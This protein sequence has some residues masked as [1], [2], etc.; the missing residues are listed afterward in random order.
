[1]MVAASLNNIIGKNNKL[2]F[3]CKEDLRW[4]KFMTMD[5][6]C[7]VGRVTYE[8]LPKLP[9]RKLVVLS[10][11]AING[12]T[13]VTV[14]QLEKEIA[15]YKCDFLPKW[16]IGGKKVYE[17]CLSKNII[18]EIYLSRIQEECEGDVCLP[19][20]KGFRKVSELKL[21]KDCILERWNK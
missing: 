18:D 13:S 19:E 14:D 11:K 4:F 7:L 16:V 21:S 2:P 1:M 17:F 10:S 12:V 8:S 9:G 20:I 6:S 3:T 5:S 15:I